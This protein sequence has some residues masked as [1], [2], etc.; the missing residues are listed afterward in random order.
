L[1]ILSPRIHGYL[2]YVVVIAFALLPQLLGLSGTERYL[3]WTLAM[4]HL[5]LTLAT[6]FPLGAIKLVPL[7]VHGMIELAVAPVLVAVPWIFGFSADP[8][9]RGA[10]GIV[11]VGNFV[12]WLVTDYSS[13]ES[14]SA[15]PRG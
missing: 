14:V 15:T 8:V 5:V 13:T 1:K 12:T 10:Y 4:V 7:R 3:A 9:A 2:D 11:G 6:D